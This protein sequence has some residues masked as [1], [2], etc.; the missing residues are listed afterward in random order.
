[1]NLV[2]TFESSQMANRQ[3]MIEKWEHD[4]STFKKILDNKSERISKAVQPYFDKDFYLYIKAHVRVKLAKET[5]EISGIARKYLTVFDRCVLTEN[6]NLKKGNSLSENFLVNIK[7][8]ESMLI[9]ALS[10]K[11]DDVVQSAISGLNPKVAAAEEELSRVENLK[12]AL[13]EIQEQIE[14]SKCRIKNSM[15][16]IIRSF[17]PEEEG[18]ETFGAAAKKGDGAVKR[19]KGRLDKVKFEEVIYAVDFNYQDPPEVLVSSSVEVEETEGDRSF[20]ENF[21]KSEEGKITYH[22]WMNEYFPLVAGG[23]EK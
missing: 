20:Y 10:T 17:Y 11:M 18:L 8:A 13:L 9:T 15:V 14:H 3:V 4:F 19:G 2:Q 1:M 21:M 5:N 22:A 12:I 23:G 7:I 6:E 16:E